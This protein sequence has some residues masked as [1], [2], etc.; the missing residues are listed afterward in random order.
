M[1]GGFGGKEDIAGQIH[2]VLAAQVT[3][4]PVKISTRARRACASTPSATPP[5]SAPRPG[6]RATARSPR[7]RP[8]CTATAA[9]TPAWAKRS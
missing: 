4:R 9:P 7:W 2:A 5:S 6:P 1:G 8:S 3:G